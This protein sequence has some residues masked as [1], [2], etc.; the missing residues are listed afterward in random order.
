MMFFSHIEL[1]IGKIDKT[2]EGKAEKH[3]SVACEGDNE[4][5]DHRSESLSKIRECAEGP[6]GSTT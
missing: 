4:A 5:N 3:Y 2:D 1:K 6:D